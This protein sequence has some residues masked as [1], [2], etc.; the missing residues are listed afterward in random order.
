MDHRPV[1]MATAR[2]SARRL[3][4]CAA[5]P[6]AGDELRTLTGLL[7]GQIALLV[8]EVERAATALPADAGPRH[9]A[10][11]CAGEARRKLRA[12]PSAGPA[13]GGLA[14]A[15]R[16]ARCL[17]ALCQHFRALTDGG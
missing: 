9:R 7:R 12:A 3:L 13:D 10:L 4:R 17:D 2:D 6:P 11:A 15:R 1:D 5:S 14:H 8:V 16:L